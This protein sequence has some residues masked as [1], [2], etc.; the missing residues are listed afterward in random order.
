MLKI[1]TQSHE[2]RSSEDRARSSIPA[3]LI[4][5][6]I[7]MDVSLNHFWREMGNYIRTLSGATGEK[8][9]FEKMNLQK[10]LEKRP[11]AN[12]YTPQSSAM[13]W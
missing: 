9:Y 5:Q 7:L 8:C 11:F 3:F 13:L 4:L 10:G 6:G 1:P 12:M 2:I